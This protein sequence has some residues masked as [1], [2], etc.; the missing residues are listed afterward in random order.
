MVDDD[1]DDALPEIV[2]FFLGPDGELLDDETT[3]QPR[4]VGM[5]FGNGRQ[6]SKPSDNTLGLAATGLT[7]AG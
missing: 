1:E 6:R 4:T 5:S 2:M 3:P 7:R